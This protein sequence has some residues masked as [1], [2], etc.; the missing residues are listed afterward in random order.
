MTTDPHLTPADATVAVRSFPRR[1]RA[2]LARPD[3]EDRWDPDEI[4]RRLS[5]DGTSAADHVLAADGVLALLDRALEQGAG[6]DDV[7]L[8]PAFADLA[9]ATWDDQHTPV[10]AL[11]DQLEATA[12][13]CA[14]RIESVPTD[15][16]ADQVGIAGVDAPVGLLTVVR[17]GVGVVAD[18]LRATQRIITEVR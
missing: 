14:G 6:H 2:L 11:L 12:T 15:A 10:P 1:F 16:W 13:R 17:Q 3:D 4:G 9:G 8:H 7:T 18:H 5:A